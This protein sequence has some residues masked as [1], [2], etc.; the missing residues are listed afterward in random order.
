[1]LAPGLR[2]AENLFPKFIL[3]VHVN[4]S[5]NTSKEYKQRY[6][7]YRSCAG[8]TSS[9]GVRYH[10]FNNKNKQKTDFFIPHSLCSPAL[11]SC[12]FWPF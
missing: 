6:L 7:V 3:F 8:I 9:L 1:M 12:Y 2:S 5:Y 4:K 11:Q 10:Y